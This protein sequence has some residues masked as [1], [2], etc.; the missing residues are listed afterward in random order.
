MKRAKWVLLSMLAS[1][2]VLLAQGCLG[3][4]W[5]GLSQGWPDNRWLNLAVDV[6]KEAAAGV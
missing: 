2:G 1:G 5:Q 3:A 6:V 4:F